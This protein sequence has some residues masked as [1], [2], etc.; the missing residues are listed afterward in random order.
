[1]LVLSGCAAS[2]PTFT[3][4]QPEDGLAIVYIYRTTSMINCCVS[5]IVSINEKQYGPLKNGGYIPVRLEPGKYTFSAENTGVGFNK[6]STTLD[7][8]AGESYFVRWFIGDLQELD[9]LS[10]ASKYEY[11][12]FPV[13]PEKAKG[14]ISEL[15]QSSS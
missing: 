11:Q 1:M 4:I 6:V 7:V 2:G 9:L 5:P 12:I 14:E 15:K 13:S 10:Y 3:N 8:A